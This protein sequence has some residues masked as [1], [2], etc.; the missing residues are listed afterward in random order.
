MS[1]NFP[2]LMQKI[3][4]FRT[5]ELV[6]LTA[7]SGVG[8]STVLSIFAKSFVESGEKIGMIIEETNNAAPSIK[9]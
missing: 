1:M 6:L 7:P 4:G 9:G 3:H 2:K 5:R 8:K